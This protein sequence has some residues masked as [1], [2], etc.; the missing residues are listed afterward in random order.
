MNPIEK[1]IRAALEKGDAEDRAFREKVYRTVQAAVER[2]IAARDDIPAEAVAERRAMLRTSIRTVES[3]FIAA[4]V[5]VEPAFEAPAPELEEEP[6]ED[7]PPAHEA[8]PAPPAPPEGQAR[9]E[10]A[11]EAQEPTVAAEPAWEEEPA[12]AP[13]LGS[14]HA[15]RSAGHEAPEVAVEP[16]VARPTRSASKHVPAPDAY[17]EPRADARPVD[18][19]GRGRLFAAL[20]LGITILTALAIGV[21][22]VADQGLLR[23]AADRDTSVPNPPALLEDEAF[24]PDDRPPDTSRPDDAAARE[25]WITVFSPADI[26]GI[27]TTAGATAEVIDVDGFPALRIRS[28]DA[29]SAILFDVGQGILE[30]IAGRPALFNIIASAGDD[31]ETQ[32]SITCNFAELGGCGRNRYNVAQGRG[33][34]LFERDMPDAAPGAAGTIAV[35][36]DVEGEGRPVDIYE[37]RVSVDR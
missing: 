3:E 30:Q 32:I 26:S 4:S 7:H 19:G 23:S 28:A 10:P 12:V 14:A 22:W 6:R 8:R 16:V 9:D 31:S 36:S 5:P 1:A 11:W 34:F 20:F 27:I 13:D 18:R 24:D 21:W 2:T 17:G 15:S 35:T 37:I 33:D 25:N 29:E